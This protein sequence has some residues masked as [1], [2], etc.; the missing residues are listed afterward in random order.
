[1]FSILKPKDL[2]SAYA[3]LHKIGV[4]SQGVEVMALK[5]LPLFIKLKDVKL[6]AANILKQ[7]MLSL[8]GDAAVAR[9]VV[10]GKTEISD[11][12]LI[13]SYDKMIKL[14]KKL[15]YQEIF[16]LKEINILL[17]KIINGLEPGK[18]LNCIGKPLDLGKTNIMGII[19][20]TPDS[21]S[22]GNK[23]FESNKAI[24]RGIQLIE[25]GADLLDIGGE[26]SRPGSKEITA[27]EEIDRVLPVVEGL[28]KYLNIPLS[29]D[30]KRAETA[31]AVLAGGAD[32]INDI[33]ALT[34]DPAMSNLL[35][36]YPEI[37]VI[38]MHM[39]G[40]PQ[41]MQVNPQYENPVSEII[42]YFE[43]RLNTLEAQGIER[44]RLVLD[45]G[46]GFGKRFS[47]NIEIINQIEAFKML[48][49]PLLLGTSRKS[50]LNQIHASEPSD[51]LEGTLATTAWAYQ[52]NISMI[53]VHD[54][55][56]NRIFLDTLAAIE[57]PHGIL[58][59]K[60][61]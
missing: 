20:V 12:I 38:L 44:K 5:M 35:K 53:R 61:K 21:F 46:I 34:F 15:N 39:Q 4:S 10:N 23:Y 40:T 41:T 52:N 47:D 14:H 36:D 33:T 9:G 45:P 24:E 6:G 13:G 55:K 51:R 56:S 50:F 8:G 7:E 3:E 31:K 43:V 2:N 18:T 29:V 60:T 58:N 26:S 28:K 42:E 27:S 54:V 1:M 22:D 16:G 30:T 57:N 19:N 17:T 32:I 49:L 48:G 37:P 11:V 25:E 59:T